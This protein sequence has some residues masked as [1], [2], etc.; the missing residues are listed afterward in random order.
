MLEK[1]WQKSEF[2]KFASTEKYAKLLL[3]EHIWQ[4]KKNYKVGF[5][6]KQL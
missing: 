5:L 1:N 2:G 3:I 6:T 4:S